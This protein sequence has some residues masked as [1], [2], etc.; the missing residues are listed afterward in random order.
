MERRLKRKIGDMTCVDL[1]RNS[2]QPMKQL[3]MA[4]EH[5]C[6]QSADIKLTIVPLLHWDWYHLRQPIQQLETKKELFC[7]QSFDSKLTMVEKKHIHQ[8]WSGLLSACLEPYFTSHG[9]STCINH[10]MSYWG[11]TETKTNHL[12]FTSFLHSVV[13]PWMKHREHIGPHQSKKC[14]ELN[15]IFHE[16]YQYLFAIFLS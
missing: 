15:K 9:P 8:E 4:K 11:K 7:S 3:E 16:K 1:T 2:R 6:F 12:S 5:F 10:T 13:Q 14:F